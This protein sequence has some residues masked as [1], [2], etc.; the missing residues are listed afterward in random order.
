[1]N[2]QEAQEIFREIWEEYDRLKYPKYRRVDL[3]TAKRYLNSLADLK[4]HLGDDPLFRNLVNSLSQT[5]SRLTVDRKWRNPSERG[6]NK[7]IPYL[8]RKKGQSLDLPFQWVEGKSGQL[9]FLNHG[10]WGA[11]N[12]M[13]M[14]A[15]GY[16][17]LLKE[18][19][20]L[21]PQDP[22]TVFNDL[23]SITKREGELNPPGNVQPR[24]SVTFTDEDFRKFTG[25]D[26]SSNEIFQLLHET[27]QVE[28]KLVFPVRLPDHK[29]RFQEKWYTMNYFS[30][31]FEFGSIDKQKRSD[32]VVTLREYTVR[33]NTLLG[34]LFAH[35]LLAKN[36]GWVDTG[37]YKLPYSAQVFYRRFLLHND[38]PSMAISLDNISAK[39]NYL[40]RNE[41]NLPRTIE[42][43][44]LEPLKDFGLISGYGKEDG[45]GGLKYIVHRR[46]LSSST[47]EESNPSEPRVCKTLI[48]GL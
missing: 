43:S 40:D 36:Y 12:Y 28:F 23:E 33:F 18:G 35:N 13:V 38:F 8:V 27:S 46:C 9:C 30:R 1:M 4:E 32:G 14:D 31:V 20:D 17:F 39:L 15:V 34:E 29:K 41:T 47:S 10:C 25:S 44:I 45:L 37:F 26:L 11:R 6:I 5:V 21:L 42:R 3:E 16:F 24:Y 2:H 19:R 7:V 22:R 48:G